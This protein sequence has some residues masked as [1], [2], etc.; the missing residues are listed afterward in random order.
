MS[1]LFIDS[2]ISDIRWHLSPPRFFCAISY[3]YYRVYD[4]LCRVALSPT[5][6][7]FPLNLSNLRLASPFGIIILL[8]LRLKTVL[9]LS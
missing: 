7:L 8:L 6:F 4:S 2:T 5:R 1:I 3:C 9:K